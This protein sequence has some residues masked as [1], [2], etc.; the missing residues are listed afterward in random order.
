[1]TMPA[2]GLDASVES[3][4]RILV[5]R[6]NHRL[7]NNLLLTPLLTTLARRFPGAEIDVVTGGAVAAELFGRLPGIGRVFAFPTNSF[8]EPRVV[9]STL[10]ALRRRDYDLAIDPMPHSRGGR[11]IL[12][13]VRARHK[14]G[15]LWS[16]P[17]R[18]RTLTRGVAASMASP[19]LALA[20][21][22][23]LR[24]AAD[25]LGGSFRGTHTGRV[26]DIGL[27]RSER[28]AG[29]FRLRTAFGD[30]PP[31]RPIV[32][33]Y[34]HATGSKCLPPAFWR[35][36]VARVQGHAEVVEFVPHDGVARLPGLAAVFCSDARRLAAACGATDLFVSADCG[37]M[38]LAAAAGGPVI[39]LFKHTAPERYAP[40]SDGSEA[41]AVTDADGERVGAHVCARLTSPATLRPVASGGRGRAL[42]AR[43]V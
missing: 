13:L 40:L 18:D 5:V 19:H 31:R 39:G 2:R 24:L 37:V 25:D 14:V 8:H 3:I 12:G 23:L 29:A 42:A 4:L 11:F 10:R 35:A 15:F 34:A 1:M 21:L 17:R 26:L 33:L 27:R 9:L 20:P 16:R 36:V 38:H 30:A 32:G 6:P 28:L 7:G 22:D 43:R 41:L